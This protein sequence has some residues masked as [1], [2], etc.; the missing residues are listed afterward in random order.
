M[1][2]TSSEIGVLSIRPPALSSPIIAAIPA[3]MMMPD[4]SEFGI[5]VTSLF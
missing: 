4:L 5:T 2:P 1:D 3:P